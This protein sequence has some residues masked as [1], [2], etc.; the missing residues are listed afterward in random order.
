M[1]QLVHLIGPLVLAVIVA[2]GKFT[3]RMY[4]RAVALLVI[5]PLVVGVL[6]S[7]RG[8]IADALFAWTLIFALPMFAA[9][10]VGSKVAQWRRRGLGFLAIP[11]AYFAL[12]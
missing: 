11:S 7:N 9:A 12:S 5:L 6:A 8:A 1:D 10:V 4:W 2:S 3:R